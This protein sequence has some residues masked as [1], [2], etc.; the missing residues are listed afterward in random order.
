[1][2]EH[3]APL[4]R[5]DVESAR[6]VEKRLAEEAY[7]RSAAALR[8]ASAYAGEPPIGS[9]YWIYRAQAVGEQVRADQHAYTEHVLSHLLNPPSFQTYKPTQ[10]DDHV[11]DPSFGADG[12]DAHAS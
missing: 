6:R 12:R 1:M 11:D 3:G 10:H 2:Q 7:A 5:D 8:E 4:R 9:R